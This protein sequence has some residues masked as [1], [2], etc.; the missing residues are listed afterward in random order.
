MELNLFVCGFLFCALMDILFS[1]A[2]FFLER[3]FYFRSR[4][5]YYNQ[6]L[7]NNNESE[8]LK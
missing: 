1:I 4:K 2:N 7:K 3:A 6:K 8:I 5:K